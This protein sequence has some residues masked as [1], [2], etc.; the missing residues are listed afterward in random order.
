MTMS[1]MLTHEEWEAIRL[2]PCPF[3]GYE[4][5][6]PTDIWDM[7]AYHWFVVCANCGGK[8]GWADDVYGAVERWNRRVNS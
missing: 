6:H 1:R 2:E 3:C 5:P 7:G 4:Y 8:S